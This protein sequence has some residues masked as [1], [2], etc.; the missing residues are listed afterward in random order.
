MAAKRAE[1]LVNLVIALL[2]TRQFSS[3]DILR[4]ARTYD[5]QPFHLSA[6]AGASTPYG[7]LIASGWHTASMWMRKLVDYH[8]REAETLRQR[9]ERIPEV[10]PSPGFRN[11]RWYKPVYAGDTLYAESEVIAKRASQSRPTQGIVTVRTTGSK[12]DGTVV[13]SFERVLLV[14]RSGHAVDDRD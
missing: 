13:I 10:G 2:G 9:G 14:P 8:K 11:L 3:D 4:F 12:A 1:R 7:G 5:P 6:E